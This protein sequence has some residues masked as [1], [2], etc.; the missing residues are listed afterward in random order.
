M[1]RRPLSATQPK[2]VPVFFNLSQ[3]VNT[4]PYAG[5]DIAKQNLQL[6]WAGRFHDL[7]NTPAGHRRLIR[8]LSAQPGAQVLCEA[9]GGDGTLPKNQEAYLRAFGEFLRVN[10]EGIYGTRAWKT[11][12]E[13]PLKIKDG[14][15]GKNKKP[16]SPQD[17]RFTCKGDTLYAFVPAPPTEDIVIKTLAADGVYEGKIETIKL[18]GSDE[19]IQWTR[20]AAALTIHRP[21][22]LPDLPVIGFKIEKK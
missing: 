20:T 9:A 13:G 5:L 19:P 16:F 11:F 12:G 6:H 14:R 18:L 15:Q 8:L 1:S 21:E 7:P 2:S 17:I 4:T 3:C 22:K 10:G